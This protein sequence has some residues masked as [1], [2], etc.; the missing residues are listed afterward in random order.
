VG[1][2]NR[3]IEWDAAKADANLRKHE[4]AFIVA[5]VAQPVAIV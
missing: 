4:I 1:D 3:G 5:S 2:F